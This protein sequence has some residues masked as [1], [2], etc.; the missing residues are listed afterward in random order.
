MTSLK[1]EAPDLASH[2]PLVWAK[3]SVRQPGFKRWGAR[4]HL[5]MENTTATS[6]RGTGTGRRD[7]PEAIIAT[8]DHK[9][10]KSLFSSVF[11]YFSF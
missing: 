6:Q 11:E 1:G 4:P 9:M 7:S 3:A 5:L 2:P 8:I 10:S